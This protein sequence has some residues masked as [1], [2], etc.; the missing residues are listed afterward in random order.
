M[1]IYPF[2]ITA[3]STWMYTT[4][5]IISAWR[6]GPSSSTRSSLHS[7]WI[8]ASFTRGAFTRMPGI[9]VKPVSANSESSS[10]KPLAEST[11]SFHTGR[12]RIL[13]RVLLAAVRL[14][15]DR[16]R[17]HRRGDTHHGEKRKRREIGTPSVLTVD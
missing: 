5:P 7:K 14:A 8:G 12:A 2:V 6:L 17:D 1:S 15:H 13:E 4:S 3:G 10:G 11:I 9:G 16:E